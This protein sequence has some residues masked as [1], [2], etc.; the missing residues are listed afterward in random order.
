MV[1]RVND[2]GHRSSLTTR[3]SK[4]LAALAVLGTLSVGAWTLGLSPDASI[5]AGETRTISFYQTHTKESLTVTYMKDG[6]Y[7]PSAMKKINRILRDWRRNEVTTI[8][9]KTIDLVWE[10][11]ADLGSN[12][13]VH[14][15]SGYRSPKTNAFLKRI[16]RKVAKRSQH[17]KGKAIDFY[18][19]DV[20][21]KM[22]RNSALPRRVG[23]VGYYRSSGG[24]SG[25]LHVDSGNVRTWGSKWGRGELASIMSNGKKTIGRR[26]KGKPGA[27]MI[28]VA[29]SGSEPE[30]TKKN[31]S[32]WARTKKLFSAEEVLDEQEVA[33]LESAYTNDANAL[34][35]L[36]AG[37]A[38]D[39]KK[40]SPV[41]ELYDSDEGDEEEVLNEVPV[42]EAPV[43][44]SVKLA[45]L[46]KKDE[47]GLGILA[48]SAATEEIGANG[49]AAADDETPLAQGYPVIK[50][51][52][53]PK[54]VLVM[55]AAQAEAAQI[56]SAEV[57]AD[58]VIVPVSA[59]PEGQQ[60]IK[61]PSPVDDSLGA[62]AD[63]G[64]LYDGDAIVDFEDDGLTTNSEGKTSFA[65][66]LRDGTTDEAPVIEPVMASVGVD[67]TS[68][69]QRLFMSTDSMFRRDGAPADLGTDLPDIMPKEAVLGPDGTGIAEGELQS[70]DGKGD[71][72][73]VNR[74]GKG[75]LEMK[76]KVQLSTN[77]DQFISVQ[78]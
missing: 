73:L 51:R 28:A 12:R 66:A 76:K 44:K 55:A 23:G 63:A 6:R 18:F 59:G 40:P 29:D 62:M 11:H 20:N 39:A 26:F 43:E 25:F 16:G 70:A 64:S 47:R 75:N 22:I 1:S 10:L 42:A 71:S 8:D 14:I 46:P 57:P 78:Q 24:P 37:A 34:T 33:P 4:A 15:V 36:T 50:P 49:V 3:F 52:L 38:V 65:A 7:V 58:A 35:D 2:V 32:L 61:K 67:D 69:W 21:T 9:P 56:A 53:K 13:P 45:S 77:L 19:P 17:M 48:Q 30:A 5:A 54:S 72:L 74:E 31:T 68:W 41:S 27:G 60:V